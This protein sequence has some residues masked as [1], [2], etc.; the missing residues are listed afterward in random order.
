MLINL[1]IIHLTQ[2]MENIK[3]AYLALIVHENTFFIQAKQSESALGPLKGCD[4]PCSDVSKSTLTQVG[5]TLST[6]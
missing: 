5:D 6:C 3:L 4:S 2:R 1:N